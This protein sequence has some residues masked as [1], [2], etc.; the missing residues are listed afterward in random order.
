VVALLGALAKLNSTQHERRGDLCFDICRPTIDS[1][2]DDMCQWPNPAGLFFRRHGFLL[3]M[4]DPHQ[5]MPLTLLIISTYQ[6]RKM[7]NK[8]PNL[9]SRFADTPTLCSRVLN[10]PIFLMAIIF[11]FSC[12]PCPFTRKGLC[13]LQDDL[14]GQFL[15]AT[16]VIFD[17]V[18]L[19]A[20][21]NLQRDMNEFQQKDV[22]SLSDFK[23]HMPDGFSACFRLNQQSLVGEHARIDRI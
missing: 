2:T 1:L 16:P 18:G 10:W 14:H 8:C 23:R 9:W 5:T 20:A 21:V 11:F 22:L 7:V 12:C 4:K 13:L 6:K 3:L 17:S 15:K 19:V